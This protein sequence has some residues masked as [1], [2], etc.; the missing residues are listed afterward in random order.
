[1][2]IKLPMLYYLWIPIYVLAPSNLQCRSVRILVGL[3][4]Q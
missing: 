2:V 3:F 1:M 4:E